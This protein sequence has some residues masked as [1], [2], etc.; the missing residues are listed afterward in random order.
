[1]FTH[2][3]FQ[4]K[5]LKRPATKIERGHL[6]LTLFLLPLVA[7]SLANTVEGTDASAAPKSDSPATVPAPSQTVPVASDNAPPP[8]IDSKRAFEYTREVTA[9]GTRYL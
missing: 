2:K 8:H 6:W 9:F 1:M 7:I 5:T 4:G 3:G